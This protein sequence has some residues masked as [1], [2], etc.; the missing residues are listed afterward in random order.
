M[1]ITKAF[2]YKEAKQIHKSNLA[3]SSEQPKHLMCYR[4]TE[5]N[6]STTIP[7]SKLHYECN[8]SVNT[9]RCTKFSSSLDPQKPASSRFIWR[10]I[11]KNWQIS[12]LLTRG[13]HC[14]H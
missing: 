1:E 7:V 2:L 14:S 6:L 13:Q 12:S 8:S 10:Q 5:Q 9:I 11:W 4:K 3:S